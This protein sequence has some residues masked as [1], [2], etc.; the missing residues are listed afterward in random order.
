MAFQQIKSPNKSRYVVDQITKALKEGTYHVGDKLP[1]ENIL[2]KEIGVG[3]T[4]IR[5]ALSAL[6]LAKI[7]E[8]RHG[9][10]SFVLRDL[11]YN[12]ELQTKVGAILDENYSPFEVFEARRILETAT[13]DLVIENVTEND[14]REIEKQFNLM[15]KTYNKKDEK[16]HSIANSGFH[17]MII[18]AS[19]N[20]VIQIVVGS[21]IDITKQSLWQELNKD[22]YFCDS[23]FMEFYLGVH[24]NILNAIKSR[25]KSKAKRAYEKHFRNKWLK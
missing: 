23:S 10:G 8:I 3:R 14:I 19:H 18:N 24:Q 22:Y 17:H 2:A 4:S 15:V 5:E 21:L 20:S 25:D 11:S 16:G 9:S 6:A 12:G 7:I 1:P 13:V